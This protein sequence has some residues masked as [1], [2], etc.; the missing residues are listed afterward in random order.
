M[1]GIDLNDWYPCYSLSLCGKITSPS[2]YTALSNTTLVPDNINNIPISSL[3]DDLNI[4][5]GF[6]T[7]RTS[8]CVVMAAL[9]RK[10]INVG[11]GVNNTK[12]Y[13]SKQKE[14]FLYMGDVE[15]RFEEIR[16][17]ISP[18]AASRLTC[19]WLADNTIEGKNHIKNMLGDDIYIIK[20]KILHE[21]RFSKVDSLWFDEYC[22]NPKDEYIKNYWN[23]IPLKDDSTSWEY[24]LEGVIEMI[25][26]EDRNFIQKYGKKMP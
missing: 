15:L 11:L 8:R 4:N 10:G 2:I 22:N 20:V 26:D 23:S 12:W 17:I 3:R 6:M 16:R 18:E 7:P 9:I 1:H 14:H 19:I 21:L 24:L 13:S 25:D 5:Y